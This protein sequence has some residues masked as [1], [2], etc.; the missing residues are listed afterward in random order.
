MEFRDT[1]TAVR[2]PDDTLAQMREASTRTIPLGVVLAKLNRVARACQDSGHTSR[3]KMFDAVAK[4]L[5]AWRPET[6]TT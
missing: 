1:S 4:E 6:G 2:G 3:A 5:E